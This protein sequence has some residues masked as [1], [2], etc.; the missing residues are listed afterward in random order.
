MEFEETSPIENLSIELNSYKFSQNAS[1]SDCT[2]AATLTIL[3]LMEITET[4]SDGKLVGALKARL[5]IWAPLLHKMGIGLD[6]QKSVIYALEKAA[7]DGSVVGNKLAT[8]NSLRFLLQTLH[9]MKI[10]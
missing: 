10:A 8:G 6:E 2:M 7:T 9:T 3:E 5:E 1:Y 4:M